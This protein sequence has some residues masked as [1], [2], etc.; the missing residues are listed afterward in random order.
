MV[1]GTEVLDESI[2]LSANPL[3]SLIMHST[4]VK[5][6]IRVIKHAQGVKISEGS[7]CATCANE[8][9]VGSMGQCRSLEDSRGPCGRAGDSGSM[10]ETRG[11]R[12]LGSEE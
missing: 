4:S 8:V 5:P 12:V 11:I 10:R 7:C 1:G 6:L 9:S 3:S 2:H